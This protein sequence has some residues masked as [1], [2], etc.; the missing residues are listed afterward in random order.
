[1]RMFLISVYFQGAP[2]TVEIV[3]LPSETKNVS[4][5]IKWKEPESNGPPITQYKVYQRIINKNNTVGEW[6]KTKKLISFGYSKIR[7]INTLFIT[8]DGLYGS[9]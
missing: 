7:I 1:M 3:G 5:I 8:N 9:V 6:N 4:V 2:A